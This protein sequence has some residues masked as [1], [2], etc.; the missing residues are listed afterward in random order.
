MVRAWLNQ[1]GPTYADEDRVAVLQAIRRVA[2]ECAFDEL[3]TDSTLELWWRSAACRWRRLIA[4]ARR[5]EGLMP[6]RCADDEAPGAVRRM[7]GTEFVLY[8]D[9][10]CLQSSG[11][12]GAAFLLRGETGQLVARGSLRR[13]TNNRAELIAVLQGL[14]ATPEG[15]RVRIETDSMY[16]ARGITQYARWAADGWRTRAGNP[17][18]HRSLWTRLIA[19][20]DEREVRV[21]WIRGHS[22]HAENQLVDRQANLAAR[23]LTN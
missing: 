8:T 14:R 12:G 6:T 10:C 9:G 17:V 2:M 5:A 7:S 13:T 20:L 21:A 18:A 23:R 16:V 1:A 11:R 4:E 19:L 3:P 15:S 22:G